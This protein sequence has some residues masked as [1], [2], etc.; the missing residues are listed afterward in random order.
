V[1]LS[2]SIDKSDPRKIQTMTRTLGHRPFWASLVGILLTLAPSFIRAQWTAPTPE[3]LS[4]TAQPEV[5]GASAVYLFREE[6]AEDA[7]HMYSVYVRIKVL[8]ESG[9]K[10]SNVE[11]PYTSY[12]AGSNVTVDDIQGRTIHPDG[13]IIPFTGKPYQKLVE[14]SRGVKSMAKVF[15][16][17]DVEIGSIIEYRYKYHMDDHHFSQ[18]AWYIQSNLFTRRA[19]YLWKPTNQSVIT[20]KEQ[21]TNAIAW[22]EILPPGAELKQT[23]VE[24]EGKDPHTI[25]ELNVHDILPTPNEEY[26]PP[27]SSFSYRVVFYYTPYLTGDEF[28]KSEG[29]SWAKERDKFISPGPGVIAAVNGLVSPTDTQ[30]QK[31][32]KIYAAVMQLEN[33]HYTRKG[34]STEELAQDRKDIHTT[35]DIWARKRGENYQLTQLFVA[36]ARAAGMKA[37]LVLVTNRNRHLFNRNYLTFSQFDDDIAIVN[38]DGKEQFFDPGSRYCPYQHLD[39]TH[40][41]TTGLRQTE[42]GSEFIET[43]HEIYSYSRLQRVANLTMD[44]QGAVTGT[45]K[46]T[47]TGSSALYWRQRPL[48][49]DAASLEDEL[50]TDMESLVPHGLE[51][52]VASIDKLADY[53][54]PLIVNFNLQGQLAVP[55]GKRLVIPGDLFEANSKPRFPHA[56][57]E[58]PVSFSYPHMSQDA[59]RITFPPNLSVESLPTKE[60][61]KLHN[62]IAYDMTTTSDAISVTARRT[63][64]LGETLFEPNQYAELRSFYSKMET[65]DQESIVLNVTTKSATAGN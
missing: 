19:H 22:N 40:T 37:Y 36:M 65:T 17:P 41:M 24:F 4:M 50:R 60:Q 18:P 57:R 53:E 44:P 23:K 33:T 6:T 43:P 58:L 15:T 45:I 25:F 16:L 64:L 35:D 13:T 5:P 12:D 31:L 30:D 8:A 46:M 10:Y 28:W 62:S 20:A 48:I 56:K 26:M 1:S 52:K 55:T 14:K 39:W 59:V 7:I 21:R 47:Y 3:E 2:Q 27:I 9:K 38:V 54:Q 11:L 51:V 29:K 34:S 63:Y 49:G 42:G 61:T 32:R